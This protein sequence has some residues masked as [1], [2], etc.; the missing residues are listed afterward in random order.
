M[1]RILFKSLFLLLILNACSAQTSESENSAEKAKLSSSLT[2]THWKLLSLYGKPVNLGAG[3]KELFMLLSHKKSSVNGFSGC[4][5]FF[6]RYNVSNEQLSF[7]QLGSTRKMCRQTME[8]EQKFLK[9]LS[10]SNHYKIISQK[11]ILYNKDK[12]LI[13]EFSAR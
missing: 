1:F 9:V 3:E 2:E 6:G 5:H 4:N 11:I 12:Q 7:S 13:A 8:Q 10:L